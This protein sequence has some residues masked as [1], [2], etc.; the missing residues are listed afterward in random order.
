MS[1]LGQSPA[2]FPDEVAA[3]VG[4]TVPDFGTLLPPLREGGRKI[5]FGDA[6]DDLAPALNHWR[7]RSWRHDRQWQWP[8]ASIV[9]VALILAAE[10]TP[11]W[12]NDPG[13]NERRRVDA[14]EFVSSRRRCGD[15]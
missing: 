3:A 2:G 12:S 11:I 5:L 13:R 15:R 8:P 6:D 1:P 14:I 4:G 9:A 10:I 7:R